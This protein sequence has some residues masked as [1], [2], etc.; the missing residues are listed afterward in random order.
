MSKIIDG[1]EI[2]DESNGLIVQAKAL[3]SDIPTTAGRFAPGATILGVNGKSYRN[4]GTTASVVWQ[5]EDSIATD[6][7]AAQ[8][9]T[10]PK[11]VRGT[12]GQIIIAQTGADSVYAAMSGDVTMSKTGATTIGASKVG[13]TELEA[14]L[15]LTG[16]VIAK[17]SIPAGTPVNAVAAVGTITVSGTPVAEETMVIG[18]TTFTF[19]AARG[20]AGEI[21]LDANNATQVTNIIAATDLD[22]TDVVCTDGTGDTV[23]VTA[24]VKGVAGNS[25][26]LTESATGIAVD[27]TGTLGATVAGVD[28]T[29]GA[30]RET[31]VDTGFIYVCTAANSI[32]GTNWKK[33]AIA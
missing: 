33:V 27:G 9:I 5:D 7:I 13:V 12:D 22:S 3:G 17:V 1:V 16:G 10:M 23:V 11:I 15:D 20:G 31:Y 14:N 19:K 30:A 6:E 4:S 21:T 29:V 25:L 26:P 32:S 8:A 28:G 2:F 18:G 24:A